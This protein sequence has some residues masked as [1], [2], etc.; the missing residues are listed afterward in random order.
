MERSYKILQLISQQSINIASV[1]ID[2][3]VDMIEKFLDSLWYKKNR[4]RANN[5]RKNTGKGAFST[6]LA[7]VKDMHDDNSQELHLNQ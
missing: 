7:S 5:T 2:K 4:P 1:D 6:F 3:Q